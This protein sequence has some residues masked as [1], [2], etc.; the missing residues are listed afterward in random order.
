MQEYIVTFG[1]EDP[2]NG[3]YQIAKSKPILAENED[4]ACNLLKDQFES[5]EGMPCDIR[6]VKLIT[7]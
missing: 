3:E 6:S 4:A 2:D 7:K 1:F 5:V